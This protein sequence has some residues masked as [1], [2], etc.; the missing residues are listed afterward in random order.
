MNLGVVLERALN[1]FWLRYCDHV[2]D[3][4]RLH[5]RPTVRAYGGHIRIGDRFRLASRPVASHLV[6]GRPGA[7]LEIGRD[8]SIAH[9]AAI[10]AWERVQIGHGT[11]IGPYVIIMDTNFHSAGSDQS[12][13]HA[14]RPVSIG[15]GCRIGSR[16]TI[17][18]GVSIADGA[19]ILA[20]SVVSSDIPAGACA[21]GSRARIIGR[22]GDAASRWDGAAAMLPELVMGVFGLATPPDLATPRLQI[23]GWNSAGTMRLLDAIEDRFGVSLA[24]AAVD[25]A[26]SLADAAAA[27]ER[28]KAA[29]PRARSDATYNGNAT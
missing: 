23:P 27:I 26:L 22:A 6:A 19:E 10:A 4:P 11:H 20:G 17:N 24:A 18:R 8:V 1:A 28:A 16:V 15:N 29:R 7:V 21:G 3:D 25:D 2:G 9:G 5:G 13:R 12:V 14:C